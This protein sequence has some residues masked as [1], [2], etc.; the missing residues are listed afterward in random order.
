MRMPLGVVISPINFFSRRGLAALLVC[1]MLY[2]LVIG[3]DTFVA[4]PLQE[5]SRY[6][7]DFARNFFA[8]S[9]AEKA[10]R[11]SLQ[12]KLK[13][14][15]NFKGK[16]ASSAENLQ[17]A[18]ELLDSIQVQFKRHYSYLYLR[19]AVDTNDEASLAESS[20]LE[21]EVTTRTAFLRQELMQIDGRSLNGFVSRRPSL[22]N[23]LFAIE[24]VRR[25]RPFTL[26]LK[27]EEL[28]SATSPNNDWEY[29][30]YAK[31]RELAKP[32]SLAGGSDQKAREEAFK[33]SY[34]S[35][36][37]QRDLYAFTLMRLAGSRTRLAQLHHFADAPTEVYFNSYWTKAEVDGLV[38]GIAKKGELYKRYQRIRADNIRKITGYK[39][40]NLWDLSIRQPG[41]KSP[42]YTIDQSSQIIRNALAPLGTDY[43]REL[44]ALLDPANGRMDIVPGEHR[45]RG[46]FSRG[47]PGTDSVFYTAGFAGSY[48]DLRV[49]THESTHAVHRQLMNRNHVL[50]AYATGPGYIFESFAIFNEFLLPDY[51]Y[52]H[53]TDPLR[54]QFYLEQFLDGKGTAMFYVAPEVALEHAVYDGVRQGNI[55]GA[56]DLDALTKRI[57][58]RYS[59]WPE[60]HDELKAE[61]MNLGLMYEDP[62]YYINYIY[63]S[64]LALKYYD[65][66]RHDPEHF[67]PSYIALLQNG[68]NAP[69]EVL[70][71]RFLDIDLNDPQL[72]TNALSVVEDKINL[73]EKSYQKH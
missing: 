65:L 32:V 56:D 14:L 53:E 70:L 16:V 42:R 67:V 50:P 62:F 1:G 23:Y 33:K 19:N 7:I 43:G 2:G 31:L 10:D 24:T 8:T 40:V 36:A 61:W 5:V 71:K 17:R 11:A 6:H 47:S 12:A 29:D 45:K 60:K 69:P 66:Y 9:A 58:S 18:L 63:G 15:E 51:L 44:A 39:E 25:Y 52:E 35:Q 13:E 4:I 41:M 49:L 27:E 20:A 37:Q 22:K 30:L 21:A 72:V 54:K 28:L 38:E 55:K 64:L 26:S 68:F 3:Q 46:G 73:L 57:Y 59:I 34:A 48:N